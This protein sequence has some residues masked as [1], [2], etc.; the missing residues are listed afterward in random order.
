MQLS[1]LLLGMDR[2]LNTNNKINL[3]INRTR[4]SS[5]NNKKD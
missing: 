2:N 4:D 5:S 1:L 3:T